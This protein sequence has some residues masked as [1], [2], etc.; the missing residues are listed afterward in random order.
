LIQI[1]FSRRGKA[2]KIAVPGKAAFVAETLVSDTV[3]STQ[4][5]AEGSLDGLAARRRPSS[6]G[7]NQLVFP[8]SKPE[9]AARLL[10]ARADLDRQPPREGP[11]TSR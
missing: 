7:E 10:Q 2:C 8:S 6:H 4:L 3:A 5:W 11:W 1:K 9:D